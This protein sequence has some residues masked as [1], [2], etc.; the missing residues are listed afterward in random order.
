MQ[1]VKLKALHLSQTNPRRT[2]NEDSL[3]ELA[4][5]IKE[6]GLLSPLL[7]RESNGEYEVVSGARR[8]KAARS[9][10]L[11]EVP[12][13]VRELSDVEAR[14]IQII[15][16][17]HRE[18]VPPLEEADGIR[19][20]LTLNPDPK[21]VAGRIGKTPEYVVA[22]VELCKLAN[23]FRELLSH[24]AI[25]IGHALL[26]ARLTP[27]TQEAT[28]KQL[29]FNSP[30]SPVSLSYLKE[31]I[32]EN[33][34]LDISTA[35][36]RKR[37][38]A[39][40]LVE[41]EKTCPAVACAV[42]PKRT[43][44]NRL[45]FPD[46]RKGDTCT[47]LVCFKAKLKAHISRRVEETK[48]V[49]IQGYG[50]YYGQDNP[51]EG[52]L[53]QE[54][55]REAKKKCPDTVTAIHTVGEERGKEVQVCTNKDCKI[56]FSQHPSSVES[57]QARQKRLEAQRAV[58]LET[59]TRKRAVRALVTKAGALDQD[60]HL[61]LA[62]AMFNR[63]MYDH[64]RLFIQVM[65]WEPQEKSKNSWHDYDKVLSAKLKD[66][67]KRELGG[68][69]LG[70]AMMAE[71]DGSNQAKELPKALTRH[72]LSMKEISKE[73]TEVGGKKPE[74]KASAAKERLLKKLRK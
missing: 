41:V 22:R 50:A 58:K 55:W 35:P 31:W 13:L 12:V 28:F 49:M 29:G 24:E 72:G 36:W 39:E 11:A 21:V 18:D 34:L 33:V 17:L 69:M 5:S 7:V 62:H 14:E 65:G 56:H 61:V 30:V 60:D 1:L 73:L 74:T 6:H 2:F 63:L 68:V 10:G 44:N 8:Y 15:E 54:H 64:Q 27:A 25:T 71:V 37:D 70:I 48:G 20:L 53:R 38:D 42:C 40:L 57:P 32:T 67:E 51:P 4:Q 16:N 19:E 46:V 47:D 23:C 43:G 26:L 45:L 59:N 3:A 66:M 9:I 52:A